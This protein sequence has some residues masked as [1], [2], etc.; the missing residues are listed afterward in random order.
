MEFI[1]LVAL[2]VLLVMCGCMA[3]A[4]RILAKDVEHLIDIIDSN[5]VYIDDYRP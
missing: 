5:G 1:I 3:I 4:L 2:A